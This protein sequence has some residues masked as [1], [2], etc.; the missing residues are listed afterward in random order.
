M[1]VGA[2]ET[3][4]ETGFDPNCNFGRT[5]VMKQEAQEKGQKLPWNELREEDALAYSE[6]GTG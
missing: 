4:E 2:R 1:D 5:K 3:F 6:D